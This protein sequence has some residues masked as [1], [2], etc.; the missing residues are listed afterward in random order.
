MGHMK[1]K[2]F[3]LHH[4]ILEKKNRKKTFQASTAERNLKATR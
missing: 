1:R 4:L 2:I 3:I